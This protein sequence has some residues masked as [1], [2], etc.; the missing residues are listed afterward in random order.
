MRL[1]S[2]EVEVV[3][4]PSNGGA[5][6]SMRIGGTDILRPAAPDASVPL[7]MASFPL[8]PYAN[9]IAHGRFRFD[10]RDHRLPLNFGDH[11]HNLHGLGWTSEWEIRDITEASAVLYYRHDNGADWPWPH[12]AIQTIELD[13][14]GSVRIVLS[15]RNLADS[16]MPIGLGFHPYFVVTPHSRLRFGAS[17][18]WLSDPDMLPLVEAAPNFFGDWATGAAASGDCLIDNVYFGWTG[19]AEI[20]RGDGKTIVLRSN[21]GPWLHLFRPPHQNFLCLEP[22]T[23]MP[24]AINQSGGMDTLR[25]GATRTIAMTIAL[26]EA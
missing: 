11:P 17:S 21:S 20:D 8:V 4:A 13:A 16:A 18:V 5:L 22:V 15:A 7:E 10:G 26:R 24:D 14:A 19:E 6:C 25:P 9:R 23:H 3:L 2:G 12:E 1:V